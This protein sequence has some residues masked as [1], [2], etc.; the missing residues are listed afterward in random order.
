MEPWAKSFYLSREW[1]RAREA[2]MKKAGGL[3]ERCLKKGLIT[4]AV[5]VHHRIHL[6]PETIKK[7]EMR[8][9]EQNLEALCLACHEREHKSK[10]RYL[11]DANG[12]V[13]ARDR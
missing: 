11:I 3:C 7:E 4:P 5:V 1:R 2:Y 10:N 13:V 8:T 9:G 12:K 6:T